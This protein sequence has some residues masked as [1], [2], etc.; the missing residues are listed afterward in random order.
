MDFIPKFTFEVLKPG[1]KIVF[2]LF[3]LDFVEVFLN[4]KI[5]LE[6]NR[7]ENWFGS[8]S[9]LPVMVMVQFEGV[10]FGEGEFSE[11]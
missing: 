7:Q 11:D 1:V 9:A 4:V 2:G 3:K 8:D 10:E 6:D 5:F